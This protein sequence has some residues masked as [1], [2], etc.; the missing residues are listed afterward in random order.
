MYLRTPKRYTQRGRKRGL[1]NLRWLWLYLI[2][3]PIIGIAALAWNFRADL[4]RQIGTWADRNIKPPQL[5]APTPTATLPAKDLEVRILS[6]LEN[7][8]INDALT[9]MQAYTVSL[10]NEREYHALYAETLIMRYQGD[11]AKRTQA[12]AA[13]DAAIN[14]SPETPEG[15][16]VKALVL[17]WSDNSQKALGYALRAKELGDDSGLAQAVM[18]GIFV[19][20]NDFKQAGSLAD[21]AMKQN[22]N[23][24]YARYVKGQ[25]AQY[26]GDFKEAIRW[27]KEGLAI[28]ASDRRQ[29]GGYI[30]VELAGVYS[31]QNQIGEATKVLN[32]ALPRDK[33]YQ[34]L[35][36][37]LANIYYKQG[38]Y[39]KALE[40]ALSCTDRNPD[41]APCYVVITRVHYIEKLYEKAAQAAQRAVDLGSNETA[42]YYYG[43]ESYRKLNRCDDALRLFTR[44][45]ALAE[46]QKKTSAIQDFSDAM[47]DCGAVTNPD[48]PPTASPTTVVTPTK[49][50]K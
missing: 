1:I 45:K 32:D 11:P 20:L 28:W 10:P 4:S 24:A 50:G 6:T 15:W 17:D 16:A 12:L 31:A 23:L 49:I 18:G 48:V 39:A 8:N 36:N 22:P 43:G 9:A 33:D 47:T 21:A 44:G 40:T 27:Y 46:E 41:Y 13:A 29:W 7:G 14:A 35:T 25:I 3:I 38:D 19:T 26:S 2:A 34:G 30:A 42:V 5:F 37:Q